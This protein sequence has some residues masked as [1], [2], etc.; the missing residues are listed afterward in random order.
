MTAALTAASA[1]RVR[2]EL[3]HRVSAA[4]S[5]TDVFAA[6]SQRLHVLVPHDSAAWVMTDPATG[7]PSAPS[8]LDGFDAPAQ[9][10]TEHWQREFVD[11][12]LNHFRQLARAERPAAALRVTATDPLRSARFRWFVRPLGFAD[13]LRVVLRS[14]DAPWAVATLWRREDR[15]PFTAGEADLVAGLSSP[16]A[17]ALRRVVRTG[18]AAG[19]TVGRD[20][21]GL[22]LFDERGRL[23][24]VNEHAAAWL[25]EL[26][27]QE[28]VP[29]RFGFELPL[30]LLV[31][32]VRSRDS[33]LA[34]GDGAARTRVRSRRGRWLVGHASTTRD[35]HGSPAGTAV[36]I[37]P[38]SPALMAP[39]VA[40][41]YGLTDREQEITRQISRGAGTGEIAAALF[42]SPH[43]VRDHVKSI[44]NKVG[45]T[46]RG[47]LVATLY[48]DQFEPAHLAGIGTLEPD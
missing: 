12:D 35:A 46:S 6:A 23:A 5:V 2:T 33:L 16:M 43:T 44:L 39:I 28:L 29:T 25:D 26:P 30:W 7:L 32:A 15:P 3:V 38:A 37:E 18:P 47:E 19:L 48:T 31:T 22:L 27:Q 17:D 36:V 13:E 45:V 34:G 24:S 4:T 11:A 8:L 14:G 9:L 1:R 42:L 10:C 20:R 41:A 21:P 40:E